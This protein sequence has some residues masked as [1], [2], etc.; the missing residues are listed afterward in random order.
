MGVDKKSLG[1]R[2]R[3]ILLEGIGR[4]VVSADFDDRALAATLE[5]YATGPA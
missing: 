3:L 5:H 4:A 1:G 2:L